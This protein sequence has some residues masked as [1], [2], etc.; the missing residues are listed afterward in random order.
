LSIGPRPGWNNSDRAGHEVA[1]S[2]SSPAAQQKAQSRLPL[3]RAAG[4]DGAAHRPYHQRIR[5]S[6]TARSMSWL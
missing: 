5:Y 4:R 2:A 3:I 6:V 1:A